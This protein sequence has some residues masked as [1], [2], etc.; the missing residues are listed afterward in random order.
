MLGLCPG[1]PLDTHGWHPCPGDTVGDAEGPD[2]HSQ[3]WGH[4]AHPVS[5]TV[6]LFSWETCQVEGFVFL[7]VL[8]QA[9]EIPYAGYTDFLSH[10]QH[11]VRPLSVA[12]YR[13]GHVSLSTLLSLLRGQHAKTPL[14]LWTPAGRLAGD[15][16]PE[17]RVSRGAVQTCPTAVDAPEFP[18]LGH[19]APVAAVQLCP[20]RLCQWLSPPDPGV[21]GL[22]WGR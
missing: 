2:S 9:A 21:P 1:R 8:I 6:S 22:C 14:F 18:L 19:S 20:G 15:V 16:Q 3:S 10:P 5:G 11:T 13:L 7:Q 4:S 17:G 12:L